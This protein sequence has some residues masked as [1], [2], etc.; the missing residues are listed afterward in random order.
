MGNGL[1]L[2][3]SARYRVMPHTEDFNNGARGKSGNPGS[4]A[5]QADAKD[6]PVTPPGGMILLRSAMRERPQV[7]MVYS[8]KQFQP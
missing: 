2:Q 5:Y 8:G 4:V 7:E 3:A 1:G 6:R